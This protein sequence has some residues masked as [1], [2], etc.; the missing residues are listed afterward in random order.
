MCFDLAIRRLSLGN[1]YAGD[2]AAEITVL[3]DIAGKVVGEARTDILKALAILAPIET[4][5]HH[6]W[7][8]CH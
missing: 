7:T 5:G 3:R 4:E 6:H 1:F 2:A 8:Q